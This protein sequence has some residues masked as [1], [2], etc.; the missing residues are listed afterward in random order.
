MGGGSKTGAGQPGVRSLAREMSCPQSYVLSWWLWAGQEG[1]SSK[2]ESEEGNGCLSGLTAELSLPRYQDCRN[3]RNRMPC[4]SR[5]IRVRWGR[6][7]VAFS[8]EWR[9]ACTRRLRFSVKS[10]VA[11][12]V[13][14]QLRT[15]Q[16]TFHKHALCHVNTI[17]TSDHW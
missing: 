1:G 17:T 14:C 7:R 4:L 15:R 6:G 2:H 5:F 8:G 16:V 10:K 11:S 3:E 12:F 13:P 9:N